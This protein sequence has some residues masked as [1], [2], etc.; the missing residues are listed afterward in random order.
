MTD[1]IAHDRGVGHQKPSYDYLFTVAAVGLASTLLPFSVTGAAVALPQL[2]NSLHASVADALWTLN[3]FNITFAALPLAAGTVADRIGRRRVLLVSIALVGFAA[4]LVTVASSMA[5][6]NLARTLQGCGAAGVLASGAAILAHATS[7]H[8]RQVAFG[9]LGTSFGTGLAIGP[10]VAGVLTQTWGWRSVFILIAV[11]SLPAWVLAT[12]A[13]ESYNPEHP[14]LDWP[15]LLTFTASLTVLS[16]AF[17]AAGAHGWANPTTL[18]LFG[19]AAALL[20]GFGWLELHQGPRAMLD[21]RLFGKPAFVAVVCQPFTVTL[22]FVV[23]LVYLP[24]YLQGA[25]GRSITESG[26]LLLSMTAPVLILPLIASVIAARTSLRAVLTAASLLIAIG[27]ALLTTLT[28]HSSWLLLAVPLVPFGIGVGLAFGVMDN[29]AVS[30][31]PVANSGAAAGIFNTMRITGESLAV[32]AAA[33]L[34]STLTARHLSAAGIDASRVAG[35]AIQGHIDPAH[36]AVLIDGVT[37]AFHTIGLCLA[38]LST[39]GAILTYTALAPAPPA[40]D[41][42]EHA[43]LHPADLSEGEMP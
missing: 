33:A 34:L 15:G 41:P 37:H 29:A 3:T 32:S 1:R 14:G 13:P 20:V 19:V 6:V 10:M 7:G 16:V 40:E 39:I 42:T 36:H 35:Q 43:A 25:A 12:R 18:G 26:L 23:L 5:L 21:V 28:D 30:T 27:A 8:R 22:G 17:V 2:S 31:V 38:A 11:L 24:A 9:I 4:A